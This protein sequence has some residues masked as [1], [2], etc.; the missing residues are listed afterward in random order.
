LRDLKKLRE[1]QVLRRLKA[2]LDELKEARN[3]SEVPQC[4]R[5]KGYRNLYRVKIGSYRLGI[6]DLG[7]GEI[8]VLRF[9]HRREIYRR[10]P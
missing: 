6:A 8:A 4:K 3:L 7:E 1:D 2:T 9:M 10:F 5:L